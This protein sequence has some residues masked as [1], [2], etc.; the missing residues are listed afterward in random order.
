MPYTKGKV[1]QYA[2]AFETFGLPP[3]NWANLR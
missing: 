2:P 3:E 1:A